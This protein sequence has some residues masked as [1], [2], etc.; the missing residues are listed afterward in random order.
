MHSNPYLGFNGQCKEAFQFYEKCLGAKVTAMMTYA[1][2]PMA[3]Q[4]PP[5][6]R[7]KVAHAR[8]AVGDTVL[9]GGDAP[10]DHYETPKGMSVTLDIDD[11]AEAER[12]FHDLAEGGTVQM[13]IQETFW[14]QRFGM[15][16]DRY[17]I[18]WMIN[19]EKPMGKTPQ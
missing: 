19:C 1:E 5:Q 6:L 14:A 18:P 3:D 15:V 16:A 11:A 12:V 17:G 8:L 10:P 9:M 7:D 4:T 13:P 2:T